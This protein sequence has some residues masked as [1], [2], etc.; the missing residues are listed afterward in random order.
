MD[1][2]GHCVGKSAH[3]E[4]VKEKRCGD[5]AE[6]LDSDSQF[7]RSTF[8]NARAAPCQR[9]DLNLIKFE[10]NRKNKNSHHTQ[11]QNVPNQMMI[12]I[13]QRNERLCLL[14]FPEEFTIRFER[15]EQRALTFRFFTKTPTTTYRL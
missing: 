15:Y 11:C 5:P 9:E 4:C 14:F 8:N 10:K 6:M 13:Q 3:S 12:R 1:C 2:N 7:Q